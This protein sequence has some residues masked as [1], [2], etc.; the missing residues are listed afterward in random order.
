MQWAECQEV[1]PI[2][3]PKTMWLVGQPAEKDPYFKGAMAGLLRYA[4]EMWLA[5]SVLKQQGDVLLPTR[6]EGLAKAVGRATP[7]AQGVAASING[8]LDLLGWRLEGSTCI[9]TLPFTAS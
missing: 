9:A 6:L 1:R 4:R 3:V 8:G 2:A 7:E 5:S